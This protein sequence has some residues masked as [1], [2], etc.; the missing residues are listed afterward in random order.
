MKWMK[1]R[2]KSMIWNIRKKQKKKQDSLNSLCDNFKTSNIHLIGLPQGEK[3]EEDI[4]NLS[5]RIMKENFPNLVKEIDMQAQEA[6]RVPNK[7]D[8]KRPTEDTS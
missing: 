1:P 8:A 5:E 2:I 7:M 3:K 6:L 4:G